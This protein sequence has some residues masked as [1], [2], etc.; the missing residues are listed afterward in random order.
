MIC[1]TQLK[2]SEKIELAKKIQKGVEIMLKQQGLPKNITGIIHDLNHI[3]EEIKAR[4][5]YFKIYIN[6]KN[7]IEGFYYIR[8][9]DNER[10]L[11]PFFEAEFFYSETPE[12]F[13]KCMDEAAKDLKELKERYPEVKQYI[14]YYTVDEKGESLSHAKLSNKRIEKI[15]QNKIKFKEVFKTYIGKII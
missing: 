3:I 11:Q 7:L 10:F 15:F 2:E 14:G 9:N 1:L 5:A 12:S 6:N 4:K 13:F 8:L